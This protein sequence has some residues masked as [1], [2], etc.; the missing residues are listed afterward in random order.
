MNQKSDEKE[1]RP[2]ELI[3]KFGIED[4]VV[5]K[6]EFIPNE[7]VHK[8]FQVSD[9]GVLFYEYATPSGVESLSYNFRLPILA[10]KV[11]HFPETIKDG[12]NGYLAPAEDTEG[13]KE[14]MKRFLE[15]PIDRNN[16]EKAT[17]LM[18]WENY[19]EAIIGE[20]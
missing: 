12:Y 2:L 4:R 19:A 7:D 11:G 6:N 20:R 16:V 8:Y 3:K 10:T 9:A 18:S 1:Y 17:E 13:M 5:V 14:V 15:E